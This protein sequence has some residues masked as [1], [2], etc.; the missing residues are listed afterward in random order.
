VDVA[1]LGWCAGVGLI[2]ALHA[3]AGGTEKLAVVVM[4]FHP[5]NVCYYCT[6]L[7]LYPEG[8]V[9]SILTLDRGSTNQPNLALFDE[10]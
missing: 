1:R 9:H 6:V 3:G 4:K 8:V 2:S 10:E 7:R 5:C